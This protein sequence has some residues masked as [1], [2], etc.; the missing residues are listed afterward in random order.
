MTNRS[1]RNRE[2]RYDYLLLYKNCNFRRMFESS[3]FC[4][5]SIQPLL[6][7][8]RMQRASPETNSVVISCTRMYRG[9]SR[10]RARSGAPVHLIDMY[11]R[12]I[13]TLSTYFGS[14]VSPS[15]PIHLSN[16]CDETGLP[17]VL[18]PFRTSSV[19]SL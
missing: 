9:W 4:E 19:H 6:T 17:H 14:N 8:I 16:L 11:L 7:S 3:R 2:P 12:V 5:R 1:V 13:H 18:H 10:L 15:L